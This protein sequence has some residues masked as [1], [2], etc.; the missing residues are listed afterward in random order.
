MLRKRQKNVSSEPHCCLH[1]VLPISGWSCWPRTMSLLSVRHHHGRAE[2]GE[3][4]VHVSESGMRQRELPDLQGDL[5]HTVA[6]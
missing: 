4:S 1:V 3:Q 6:L 2:G 5:A